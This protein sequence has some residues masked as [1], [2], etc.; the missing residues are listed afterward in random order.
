MFI[1]SSDTY[2]FAMHQSNTPQTPAY[3]DSDS[4]SDVSTSSTGSTMSSPN[5]VT[6]GQE[7]GMMVYTINDGA[8]SEAGFRSPIWSNEKNG[9]DIKMPDEKATGK[10][11]AALP[12]P[13][14]SES[15]QVSEIADA[16]SDM[17]LDSVAANSSQAQAQAKSS[18]EIDMDIIKN[19]GLRADWL[20]TSRVHAEQVAHMQ[21]MVSIFQSNF[22]H[23]SIPVERLIMKLGQPRRTHR[24]AQIPP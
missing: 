3:E 14:A 22:T 10:E 5:S 2:T 6:H 24:L 12:S 20:G 9:F 11:D 15:E 16:V 8:I 7:S 23:I 21:A 19:L 1:S 13:P 4:G 17:S 18:I